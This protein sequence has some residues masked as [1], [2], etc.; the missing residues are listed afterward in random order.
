LDAL[1]L[2]WQPLCGLKIA[3]ECTYGVARLYGLINHDAAN[4]SRRTD[5]E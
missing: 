3:H 2:R 1:R 5:D 4:A